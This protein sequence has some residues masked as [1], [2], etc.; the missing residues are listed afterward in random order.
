MRCFIFIVSLALF[1]ACSRKAPNDASLEASSLVSPAPKMV[2]EGEVQ[3]RPRQLVTSHGNRH[4]GPGLTGQKRAAESERAAFTAALWN[5][6]GAVAPSL[7]A[8]GRCGS[9]LHDAVPATCGM[10]ATRRLQRTFMACRPHDDYL[11][12]GRE[13]QRV[14]R[15][16]H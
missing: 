16:H 10:Q 8:P 1:V 5:L 2:E 4:R 15:H 3:R 13:L 11:E 9:S 6:A 12:P 14:G 7:G